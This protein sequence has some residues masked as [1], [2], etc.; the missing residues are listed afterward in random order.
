MLA[1]R[2]GSGRD[3]AAA[4]VDPLLPVA[5]LVRPLQPLAGPVRFLLPLEL[6]AGFDCRRPPRRMWSGVVEW[7]VVGSG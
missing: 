4:P 2:P 3:V 5:C 6:F 7:L 1:G